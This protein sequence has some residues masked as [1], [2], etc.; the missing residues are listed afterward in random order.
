MQIKHANPQNRTMYRMQRWRG[1]RV[2]AGEA[3]LIYLLHLKQTDRQGEREYN[4][5]LLLI[6]DKKCYH[7]TEQ[8]LPNSKQFTVR[9]VIG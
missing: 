8:M 9:H 6:Y 2:S 4:C 7:D 3:S 5:I 1:Q